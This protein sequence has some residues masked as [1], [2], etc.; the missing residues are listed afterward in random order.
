MTRKEHLLIMLMEECD[1]VSQRASKALRFTLEEIQP[2]QEFT[3]ADR[4][5]YEF[6]DL[7]AIMQMLQKEGAIPH[8]INQPALELKKEKVKKFLAYSKEVGTLK[9]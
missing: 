6:N 2:G 9:E 5:V 4:I 1:E 7:Y 3:N 8:I